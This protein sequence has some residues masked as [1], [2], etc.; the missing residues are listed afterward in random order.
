MRNL[1]NKWVRIVYINMAMNLNFFL[2]D[3]YFLLHH[4]SSD[5]SIKHHYHDALS[6]CIMWIAQP[7]QHENIVSVGI[8]VRWHLNMYMFFFT[9]YQSCK[10]VRTSLNFTL[11]SFFQSVL[12]FKALSSSKSHFKVFWVKVQG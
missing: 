10:Q 2:K 9:F 7:L 1:N 3:C 11:Q 12:M 5:N 4:S 6:S 8:Q